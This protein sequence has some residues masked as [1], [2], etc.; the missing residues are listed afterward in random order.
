MNIK[1]QIFINNYMKMTDE[2]LKALVAS[3]AVAQKETDAQ[4]KKNAESQKRTDELMK[5]TDEIIK[6]NEEK[7]IRMG[8]TLGNIGKNNGAVAEDFFY[9]S[10]SKKKKLGNIKY[11]EICQHWQKDLKNVRGE[12]DIVMINGKE[13]AL[14]EV[15]Y[16]IHHYDV[17]SMEKQIKNFKILFPDYKNYKIRGA[18]AS[19]AMSKKAEEEILRNGYFALKQQG[20]H[21]EVVSPE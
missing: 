6:K 18:F 5:K 7:L 20:E 9:S 8:I 17:E 14:V 21:V 2:E 11:D 1:K 15:K 12:Y 3:L 13:V 16:K 19:L 10:L 4:I